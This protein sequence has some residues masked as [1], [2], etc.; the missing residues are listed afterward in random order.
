MTI[1]LYNTNS[2]KNK[3]TKSLTAVDTLTGTLREESSVISPVITIERSSPTGFN[4]AYIPEFGRYYFVEDI[5]VIRNKLLRLHLRVD[6]LMS[7][8]NEIKANT[9]IVRKSASNYN[10]LINDNSLRSYQN[11]LYTYKEFP[12]GFGEAFEYV[13]LVAGS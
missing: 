1:N 3:I 10:V 5:D 2:P 11:D 12:N 8:A 6:P 13:L 9:A 4:Y 7:F